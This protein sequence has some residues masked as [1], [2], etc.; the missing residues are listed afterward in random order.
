MMEKTCPEHGHFRDLYWADTELYLKAEKW[1]FADGNGLLNPRVW[2]ATACPSQCG[3]CNRHTS[4]TGLGNIDLTNRCD[5]TCPICFANS[6]VSGYVYEPSYEEVVEMLKTFRSEQPV[7]GR[8]IQ[9]SGGEP[10]LHPRFFDIL[11]AAR[12]LGFSHIQVASNGINL[13]DPKFAEECG[14]AGLHTVYLQFDG[15]SDDVY[16]KTRGRPLWAIKQKAIESIRRSGV[17]IVFVP[18][19]VKGFNDQEVGR[20]LRYALENIDVVSGISYQPVVFTGRISLKEREEKRFTL[21]DMAWAVET[22]TGL[23]KARRDWYPTGFITPFTRLVA[24]V[25]GEETIQLTCHPHCSLAT[26]LFVSSDGKEAVAAPEFLDVEGMV[27]DLEKLARS[28]SRSR[29]RAFAR[30]KAFNSIRRHFR[31]DKAPKGLTFPVFLNTL[32]G[33]MDKRVGRGRG[34]A[35]STYKTLLVAG[36]HFMDAYNYDVDRVRRCVV[37]YAAPNGRLY[38]FCTYNS[39]PTFR[40]MVEKRYCVPLDEWKGTTER[41]GPSVAFG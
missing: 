30:V 41:G 15:L 20:I 22:Q 19:I 6:N 16:T 2:N 36:M 3:L 33:L 5:L 28:V 29:F 12:R 40:D 25:R 13:S 35:P 14:K 38:P 1:T 17:K 27:L 37:H 31:E 10:T 9:F 7:A 32:Q 21:T 34:A 24:A 39:G 4:H 8:V 26:Y 23:A 18:T 11:R